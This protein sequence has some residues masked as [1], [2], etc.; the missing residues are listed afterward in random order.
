MTRLDFDNLTLKIE[1][2]AKVYQIMPVVSWYKPLVAW[3]EL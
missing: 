2:H 3:Y 1:H